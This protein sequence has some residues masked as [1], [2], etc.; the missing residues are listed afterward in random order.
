MC[1]IFYSQLAT[2]S[3]NF[4]LSAHFLLGF[5]KEANHKACLL[6]FNLALFSAVSLS[7]LD[8]LQ[9]EASLTVAH[10]GE[11]LENLSN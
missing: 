6:N 11:A 3:T 7:K 5:S 8:Y 9:S 4:G 10:F 2:Y 1:T